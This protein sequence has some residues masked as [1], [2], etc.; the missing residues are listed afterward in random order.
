MSAHVSSSQWQSIGAILFASLL[1]GTT[2]SA[3][4]L[5]P[6][7]HP[8][9]I[10][11]FA[12][13]LGGLLLALIAVPALIKDLAILRQHVGTLI[14]GALALTLY[15]LA[16]YTS[17]RWSGVAIGT[18]V[19]IATAP[20]FTV[21]FER[22][23]GTVKALS[24]QWLISFAFGAIGVM[25][26]TL[27]KGGGVNTLDNGRFTFGVVLGLVAAAS[28]AGYSLAAKQLITLGVRSQ[29]A[30]GAI[31]GL[32]ACLLLPTLFWTGSAL[33]AS[34]INSAVALYMAV[35]PMFVGYLLF[36]FGLRSVEVRT[37]TLL[38][39]FE[40]LVAALLAV[41]FLGERL[42]IQGW[43]GLGLISACLLIQTRTGRVKKAMPLAQNES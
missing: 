7:I 3:A 11:A 31:F 8:L 6:T 27:T 34:G 39:L 18:V 29:S 4:A 25:L 16:F 36:G 41:M 19:S 43:V 1:W 10:G 2:G 15:P 26:L 24:T 13:G 21:C 5:A 42:S 35:I 12:M 32:G 17:M 37:A 30:M 14:L 23:F 20:L 22:L 9:A 33:F 40:P 28:Y 38:T